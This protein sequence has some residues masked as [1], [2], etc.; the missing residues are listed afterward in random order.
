[1]RQ[2]DERFKVMNEVLAGMKVIK[3]YAWEPSFEE[4]VLGYRSKELYNIKNVNYINAFGSMSALLSPYLVSPL[5]LEKRFLSVPRAF[6]ERT[7]TNVRSKQVSLAVFAAYV[8][9]GNILDA[10][11]AFVTLSLINLLN[12]PMSLLPLAVANTAQARLD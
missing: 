11:K 4:R 6:H 8:V 5:C 2:K 9:A 10:N 3:L 12:F 1:M 7:E